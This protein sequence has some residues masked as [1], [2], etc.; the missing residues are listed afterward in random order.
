MILAAFVAVRI[1]SVVVVVTRRRARSRPLVGRAVLTAL[2]AEDQGAVV[3][4]YAFIGG[5]CADLGQGVTEVYGARVDGSNG[6]KVEAAARRRR[7]QTWS[8]MSVSRRAWG[9]R[10]IGRLGS[11]RR[12]LRRRR[13]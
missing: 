6:T 12:R 13:I 1:L 2:L 10:L 7:R 8:T 9:G 3:T 11:S 4:S 5:S